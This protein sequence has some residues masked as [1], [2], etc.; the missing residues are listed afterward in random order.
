MDP[1]ASIP[2]VS[3]SGVTVRHWR[4]VR[5]WRYLFSREAFDAEGAIAARDALAGPAVR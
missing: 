4:F 5:R 1:T 2:S 3:S